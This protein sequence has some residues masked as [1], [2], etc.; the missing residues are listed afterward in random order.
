MT[1]DRQEEELKRI[2]RE[3]QAHLILVDALEVYLG[4]PR[5]SEARRFAKAHGWPLSCVDDDTKESE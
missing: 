1:T 5:T 4:M 3:R 2:Q